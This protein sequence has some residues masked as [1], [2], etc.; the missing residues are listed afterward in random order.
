MEGVC[1]FQ[2]FHSG[3]FIFLKSKHTYEKHQIK[4]LENKES[5]SRQIF[6]QNLRI[7]MHANSKLSFVLKHE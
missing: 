4:S 6:L 7:I 3:Y 1:R 5:K 2:S